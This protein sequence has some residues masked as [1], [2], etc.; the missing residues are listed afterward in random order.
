MSNPHVDFLKA[1]ITKQLHVLRKDYES[2]KQGRKTSTLTPEIPNVIIDGIFKE[3][4]VVDSNSSTKK[5]VHRI[6]AKSSEA[7]EYCDVGWILNEDID[8][9]MLCRKSAFGMFSYKHHCK[10]CGNVMCSECAS[11][12]AEINEL[13]DSG[14]FRVCDLCFYGQVSIFYLYSFFFLLNHKLFLIFINLLIEL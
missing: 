2:A 1:I 6:F 8:V 12:T 4:F 11:N 9:C 14:P 5:V 7:L 3:G 10:A 13:P